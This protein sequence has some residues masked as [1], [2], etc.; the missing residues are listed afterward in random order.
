VTRYDSVKVF[1]ICVDWIP[2]RSVISSVVGIL[3]R[4][5]TQ[6][7]VWELNYL[8]RVLCSV[9]LVKPTILPRIFHRIDIRLDSLDCMP[10]SIVGGNVKGPKKKELTEEYEQMQLLHG[11]R[12]NPKLLPSERSQILSNRPQSSPPSLEQVYSHLDSGSV[13]LPWLNRKQTNEEHSD[14]PRESK[15]QRIKVGLN[16]PGW[17]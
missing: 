1:N 17:L 6:G 9:N 8:E 15:N 16:S 12:P 13:H 2:E 7:I 4:T 10:N 5:S 3:D 14:E 11:S